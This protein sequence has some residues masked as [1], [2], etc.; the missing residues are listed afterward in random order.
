MGFISEW[1][2]GC[3]SILGESVIFSLNGVVAVDFSD[4]FI[5][6]HG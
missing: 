2:Q 5:R 4:F 6:F 3:Y 1:N